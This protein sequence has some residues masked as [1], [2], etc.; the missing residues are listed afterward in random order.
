MIINTEVNKTTTSSNM[1]GSAMTVNI[2]G[3]SFNFI[4]DNLYTQ[5]HRAIV[6]ELS[7]NA[8]DAH[9][10]AKNESP[11]H[12]QVPS[13][14]SQTF[15]IRDFGV[16][17]NPEEI[18]K[19]LNTLYQS[20]KGESNDQIGGF[21]LGAKS[22]FSLVQSF[23][24]SSYKDGIEY[25]CFWYRDSEGI[26]ILKIQS[27]KETEE[28]NGIK[29][30]INFELKDVQAI[31][32]A[33]SSELLGLPIRPRFFSDINDE[34]TEFDLIGQSGITHITDTPDY[35]ILKETANV[36][37]DTF[38]RSSSAY[39]R[40]NIKLLVSIGGVLYP[41]PASF[42]LNSFVSA[43]SSFCQLFDRD[44]YF[45]VKLPIG[46]LKLPS[47][48]EHI[49]DTDDNREIINKIAIEATDSFLTKLR[50]Q[51]LSSLTDNPNLVTTHI[52]ELYKYCIAN[53]LNYQGA[54]QSFLPD[55]VVIDS[56]IDRVFVKGSTT[57]TKLTPN[58]LVKES[59]MCSVPTWNAQ[60]NITGGPI[61]NFRKVDGTTYRTSNS[62]YD[63]T[64]RLLSFSKYTDKTL[65]VFDDGNKFMGSY[66]SSLKDI[67]TYKHIYRCNVNSQSDFASISAAYDLLRLFAQAYNN[68]NLVILS[69]SN[70]L[71]K[72]VAPA[73]TRISTP[74]PVPSIR[75]ANLNHINESYTHGATAIMKVKDSS[76]KYI[77]FD[78][79]YI[80]AKGT[81]GYIIKS[82]S[83]DYLD[84]TH[85]AYY[86]SL[87]VSDVYFI[88]ESAEDTLVAALKKSPLVTKIVKI[89]PKC[90]L[91]TDHLDQE[92]LKQFSIYYQICN[93]ITVPAMLSK[94]LKLH[95]DKGDFSLLDSE[96]ILVI[97]SR[98][99][100]THYDKALAIK[101][102]DT[103]AIVNSNIDKYVRAYAPNDIQASPLDVFKDEDLLEI[104]AQSVQP[105]MFQIVERL[106]KNKTEE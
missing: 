75:L 99:S 45:I 93:S 89:E 3:T 72:P 23:F 81:V 26:P 51:Y 27:Q 105:V 103:R 16:G 101:D 74:I 9:V 47:T 87:G 66:L 49:L 43:Q 48:R 106:L 35:L 100:F 37:N 61:F 59:C 102:N 32:K 33:C 40:S 64:Q 78:E 69:G 14:F 20:S 71:T 56:S 15:I 95:Y 39:S 97:I 85:T 94:L 68:P 83:T 76:D 67:S 28:P 62:R 91:K 19:Y 13:K 90:E 31:I 55:T 36:L 79:S 4:L 58:L 8:W 80:T 7:C 11:F 44:L 96:R 60:I 54:A 12:I 77:P 24:I 98:G 41:L 25:K 57:Y 38:L 92:V 18:D 65:I 63:V 73:G 17:L 86:R 53:G 82:D 1:K 88:R 34:S 70:D 52:K 46:S 2:T 22:P 84:Y 21:G 29:Y 5:P 42:S 30:I 6:R 10:Q 50:E 104:L